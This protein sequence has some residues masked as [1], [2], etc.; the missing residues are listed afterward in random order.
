[1]LVSCPRG[2]IGGTK[3]AQPVSRPPRRRHG[4]DGWC[5]PAMRRVGGACGGRPGASSW[6]WAIGSSGRQLSAIIS[7]CE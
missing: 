3:I 5:L 6:A 7:R 1:M 2:L 4:A